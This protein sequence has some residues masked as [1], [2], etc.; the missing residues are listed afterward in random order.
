[1]NLNSSIEMTLK[2]TSDGYIII[3]LSTYNNI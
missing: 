2:K 3:G 1:M